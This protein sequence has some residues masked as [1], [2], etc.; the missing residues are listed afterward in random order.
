MKKDEFMDYLYSNGIKVFNIHDAVKIFGK[1]EKYVSVRLTAM[2]KIKRL[3][4]SIYYVNGADVSEI[5]S[6]IVTPSY[7]SLISAFTFH[8]VTTQMPFEIQVISP[9]QRKEIEV[10]GYRIRFIRFRK[11]RIFG[12]SRLNGSTVASFEKA[13]IDCLYLNIFADESMEVAKDNISLLDNEK[14]IDYGL[15]MKSGAL[16]SRLGFLL[17]C[18]GIDATKLLKFRS[19]RYVRFGEGGAEKNTKW[20]VFY[21]D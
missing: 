13:I 3:V 6:K 20:R 16:V 11:D 7:I 12:Y 18:L 5:A 10:E 8:S 4:R 1:P 21:A 9:I 15:R 14:L 19:K 17:E 2:T